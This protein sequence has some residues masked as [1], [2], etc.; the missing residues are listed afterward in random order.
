MITDI[1][2]ALNT[3]DQAIINNTHRVVGE[4]FATNL[5]GIDINVTKPVE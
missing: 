1:Y 3:R 5:Y 2:V 4:H